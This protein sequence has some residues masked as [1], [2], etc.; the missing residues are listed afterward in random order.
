MLLS[1][2]SLLN[3]LHRTRNKNIIYFEGLKLKN[4][5]YVEPLCNK[6]KSYAAHMSLAADIMH[7][8]LLSPQL[9]PC[10]LPLGQINDGWMDRQTQHRSNMLT[11]YVVRIKINVLGRNAYFSAWL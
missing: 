3:V 6:S 7:H 1:G 2:R 10:A 9:L 8:S 5:K 4:D 11:E